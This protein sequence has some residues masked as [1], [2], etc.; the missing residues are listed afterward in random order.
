[1]DTTPPVINCPSDISRL[2]PCNPDGESSVVTW[3][4]P[5]TTDDSGTVNRQTRTHQSGQS[6]PIGTTVVTYTFAD[7]SGNTATCTFTVT[8]TTTGKHETIL[9]KVVI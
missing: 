6:F 1:M 8:I 3:Q 7:P 5:A 9:I 2:I 4:E